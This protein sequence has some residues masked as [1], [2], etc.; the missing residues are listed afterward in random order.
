MRI[1][2]D[3]HTIAG[4]RELAVAICELSTKVGVQVIA[5]G[6]ENRCELEACIQVG[7]K[8]GQGFYLGHPEFANAPPELLTAATIEDFSIELP[9]PTALERPGLCR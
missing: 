5:E 1:T 2:R 8:F 9:Q 3:I 6:I 4:R 7:C